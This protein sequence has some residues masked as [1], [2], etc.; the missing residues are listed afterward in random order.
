MYL[1]GVIFWARYGLAE[2]GRGSD[3]PD[4]LPQAQ[5]RPD[6]TPTDIVI[7]LSV[8]IEITSFLLLTLI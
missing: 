1:R 3:P 7:H 4:Y 2:R 8:L 5:E 6:T